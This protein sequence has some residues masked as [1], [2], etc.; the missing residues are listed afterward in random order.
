MIMANK[1]YYWETLDAPISYF[2][3]DKLTDLKEKCVARKVTPHFKTQEML[4]S[5]LS[6]DSTRTI[7]AFQIKEYG[8]LIFEWSENMNLSRKNKEWYKV[9]RDANKRK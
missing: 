8:Q 5:L 2:E 6:L 3:F 9:K 1:F 4:E 7:Y